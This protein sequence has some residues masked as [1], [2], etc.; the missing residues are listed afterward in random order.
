MPGLNARMI[1]DFSGKVLSTV[2]FLG[3]FNGTFRLL[4]FHAHPHY[5]ADSTPVSH[6]SANSVQIR[7]SEAT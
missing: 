2:Y 3:D 7:S 1:P 5:H 4:F 6:L